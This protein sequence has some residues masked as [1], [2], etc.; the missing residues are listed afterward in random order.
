MLIALL[1]KWAGFNCYVVDNRA[2]PVI[3]SQAKFAIRTIKQA[4]KSSNAPP[5]AT[6][7]R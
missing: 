4:I 1:K 7:A 3:G 2:K 5:Q 6:V